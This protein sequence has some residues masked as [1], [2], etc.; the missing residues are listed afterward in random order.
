MFLSCKPNK[1]KKDFFLSKQVKACEHKHKTGNATA[2]QLSSCTHVLLLQSFHFR[3]LSG[4][5]SSGWWWYVVMCMAPYLVT[6]WPAMLCFDDILNCL[7]IELIRYTCT[8][9]WQL[10]FIILFATK[11]RLHVI[12]ICNVQYSDYIWFLHL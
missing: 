1:N 8:I 12:N 11:F 2:M 10:E 4:W 6:P 7:V 5:M 9:N 3:F